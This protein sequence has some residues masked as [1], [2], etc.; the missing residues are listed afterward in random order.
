[1]EA[2]ECAEHK[3]EQLGFSVFS[4]PDNLLLLLDQAIFSCPLFSTINQEVLSAC[5]CLCV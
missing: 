4:R 1:M 2:K 5:L 3:G